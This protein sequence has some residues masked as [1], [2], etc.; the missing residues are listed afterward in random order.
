MLRMLPIGLNLQVASLCN[1]SVATYEAI[2]KQ[3]DAKPHRTISEEV[4][5]A[6]YFNS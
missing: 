2:R 5:D 4:W 3:V 1:C 6:D